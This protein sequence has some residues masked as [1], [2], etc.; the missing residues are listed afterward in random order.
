MLN[1]V[2]EDSLNSADSWVTLKKATSYGDFYYAKTNMHGVP[3][4]RKVLYWCPHVIVN[5]MHLVLPLITV[6][7]EWAV[8]S[9]PSLISAEITPSQ[10]ACEVYSLEQKCLYVIILQSMW[11]RKKCCHKFCNRYPMS[12]VPCK[13]AAQR[14]TEKFQLPVQCWTERKYK[15]VYTLRRNLKI[16]SSIDQHFEKSPSSSCT[17]ST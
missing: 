2:S 6:L 15:S 3:W 13:T 7:P 14:M 1:S 16:H 4:H 9:Q 8:T 17:S 10:H 12:T 11:H 5:I